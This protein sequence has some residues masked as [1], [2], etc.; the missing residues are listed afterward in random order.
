MSSREQANS[1]EEDDS[2]SDHVMRYGYSELLGQFMTDK[3]KEG[4]KFTPAASWLHLLE[5]VTISSRSQMQSFST[6]KVSRM[7]NE[8]KLSLSL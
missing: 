1:S 8:Q 5:L 4:K 3:M 6:R 2:K 7:E